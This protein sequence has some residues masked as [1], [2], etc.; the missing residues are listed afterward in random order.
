MK[1]HLPVSFCR[2]LTIA[3]SP[4]LCTAFTVF[5]S[6]DELPQ[7]LS[8]SEY[9]NGNLAYP[10]KQSALRAL[11]EYGDIQSNDVSGTR[12]PS[13]AIVSR[14]RDFRLGENVNYSGNE[15]VSNKAFSSNGGAIFSPDS[16][17]RLSGNQVVSFSENTAY[18]YYHEYYYCH[19]YNG[20]AIYNGGAFT[21]SENR[22]VNFR[23]NLAYSSYYYSYSYN[24]GAIYNSG[25]ASTFTLSGNEAVNFS[26]NTVLS[27]YYHGTS[28]SS[29]YNGGAIYNGG[30]FTL[31]GNGAVNFSANTTSSSYYNSSSSALS[32]SGGVI[33]NSGTFSLSGNGAVS[34]SG[35]M[36]SSSY[37]FGSSPSA[38]SYISGAIYNSG[39][40]SLIGNVLFEKNTEVTQGIYRL[41]SI[42]SSGNLNLSSSVNKHILIKDSVYAEGTVNLNQDGAGDI[43]FTG[44]STE[45]DLREVKGGIAGTAEEILNSRTSEIATNAK[46]Y[47]G[48]LIVEDSAILMGQGITVTEGANATIRL[49]DATLDETGYAIAV[50]SGSGLELEGENV[51]KAASVQMADGAFLSFVMGEGN[52]TNWDAQLITGQLNLKVSGDLFN[53]HRLLTLSDASQY[54]TSRWTSDAVTVTGAGFDSLSWADGV[55]TYTPH[56]IT[57]DADGSIDEALPEDGN[58][59]IDGKGHALTVKNEVQLV[60]M[61][62][63][64]GTVKLEGENNGIVSVTLTEGGELV[65]TAGAGLKT[66][67][68]ISMVASGKGELVISGDITIDNKGMKGKKGEL[69]SVSHADAKVL[70]DAS[71][72]NVRVEDSV[73]DLAEGSTVGFEHVVLAATTRITDDPATANLDDVTAELVMGVNTSLTGSDLL[74]AG[75]SLEQSGNPGVTLTLSA[76]ASVLMLEATTFDSLTLSGSSLVLELAGMTLEMFDNAELIAVSFTSGTDYATFDKSLAVT[77]SVDGINYE[78]GYTMESDDTPTTMYF[79]GG[80][81]PAATPEPATATLSLLALAALAARRRRR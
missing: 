43:I 65:L 57:P 26:G 29:S 35:N 1:P 21:L 49:N 67:D 81:K 40:F 24:G 4:V 63:K 54:D 7:L 48:R 53:E 46:L 58:A 38:S 36:A 8:G 51:L 56:V 68:I 70:G 18:S 50:S 80:K 27:S 37:N 19:S 17:Y 23:E 74:L 5:A 75:T 73:I 31:S 78:R 22:A 47:G 12:S 25:V 11:A 32:Y 77:L 61:A 34:F 15:A 33:Y 66:G 60:Q 44:V 71:I 14:N 6:E 72:S 62:L 28:S 30:T 64:N 55:L 16:N 76:D 79:R 45:A 39:T 2:S 59:I 20:G 9:S 3:I 10:S 41:R 69:A 52:G 42:Y 13:G